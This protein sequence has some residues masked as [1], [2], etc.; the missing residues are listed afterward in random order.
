MGAGAM[1]GSESY[2][3]E[4]P[5]NIANS[6]HDICHFDA[7]NAVATIKT[8][9]SQFC[10]KLHVVHLDCDNATAVSI[11]HAG[12]DRDSFI[13]A[14]TRQ[15]WLSCTNYNITLTAGHIA[16]HLSSSEDAVSHWHM[17]QCYKDC[18]SQL[19]QDRG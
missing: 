8:R 1:A 2:H 9:E 15:L 4:F 14:C 17:G 3:T 7:L 19:V 10:H 13:Q 11:F 6:E 5:S 16:N 18:I 12:P